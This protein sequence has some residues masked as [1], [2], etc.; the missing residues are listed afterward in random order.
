MYWKYVL[1]RIIIGLIIYVLIIFIYSVLFN[2]MFAVNN[3][4]LLEGSVVSKIFSSWIDTLTFNYG[5]SNVIR[6]FKGETDVIK[7]V[8]ERIPNT[9]LLFTSSI[10]IDIFFGI[11]LGIKKAQKAGSLMDKT[12]SIITMICYG[13]PVWWVGLVMIMLF[14]FT[15]SLFPSNG[16]LSVPPP[17]TFL[18]RM[19]DIMYHMFLPVTTLVSL[20]FWG[21]AYLTRNIVLVNLQEDFIMSARARGIPERTVLYGH[22]LRTSAPPILTMSILSLINSFSGALIFEGIFNWPGMGNL[23]WAAVQMNDIPVLLGNLSIT[24]LIYIFGM[25]ILDLVYGFLD[26]R[27]KIDGAA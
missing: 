21:R 7:I 13:L 8:L 22:A 18:K 4:Y 14:A 5:Q 1:K 23:Y 2:V 3:R 19:L 9:L 17:E 12:T 6:S 24:T 16:I 26:P 27:I 15:F 10:I 25:I 11:W 20:N